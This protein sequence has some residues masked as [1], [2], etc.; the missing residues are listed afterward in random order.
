[1]EHDSPFASTFTISPQSG[2]LEVGES[3]RLSI[4]FSSKILGEFAETFHFEL[5]GSNEPLVCQI[6]V[7]RICPE[8]S[9]MRC[10]ALQLESCQLHGWYQCA[11]IAFQGH[12]LGPSFRF[13]Q[14]SLNFG[15]VSYD[16]LNTRTFKLINTCEIPLNYKFRVPQDG[17]FTKK[18]FEITPSS[19]IAAALFLLSPF[20]CSHDMV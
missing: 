13:D 10:Q 12:V 2:I 11:V 1:M 14:E 20:C 19:G 18:E 3:V 4:T 7:S 9:P 17:T 5:K 6:K 16:F 15:M 8:A